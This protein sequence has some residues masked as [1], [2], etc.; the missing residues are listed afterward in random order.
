[1]YS[2]HNQRIYSLFP[3]NY[4]TSI[5]IKNYFDKKLLFESELS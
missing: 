2:D 4:G 5:E 3:W 1:M